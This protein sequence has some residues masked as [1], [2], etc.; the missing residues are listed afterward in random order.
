MNLVIFETIKN[1]LIKYKDDND[2]NNI[3]YQIIYLYFILS[4]K[5]YEK[6]DKIINF[7][8]NL[9]KE[10]LINELEKTNLINKYNEIDK[11]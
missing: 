2:N 5:K 7:I 4:K 9:S 6:N 1:N 8:E 3:K 11:I 10:N